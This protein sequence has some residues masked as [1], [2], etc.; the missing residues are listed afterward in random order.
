MPGLRVGRGFSP[1][2]NY[3]VLAATTVLPTVLETVGRDLRF[4]VR[5]LRR[6][7]GFTATAVLTLALGICA[8]V[9]IFAFVE[10]ALLKPLPYP[11]ATRLSGVFER[12]E[13]FPRSNLSYLDYLDWKRLNTVFTSLSAYQG[14]GMT[15]ATPAGA[16]RVPAARVSDDFFR[17]LRITPILGR[18]F[19]TGEDLAGAPRV[20]ML[21]YSA[22]QR[23]FGGRPDAVGAS[24]TLNGDPHVIIGV[25][26]REFHFAPVEPADF[27]TTLHPSPQSCDARR[28]CHNMFG[29]ARLRDGVSIAAAAA[30]IAA[31]ARQLE[32]QYPDT[33]RGQGSAIV[34]LTEVIVGDIRPTL[35]VLLSGAGLLLL[36]AVVNVAGLLI[37]R[38]EA[39][40]KELEIRAALG[41]SSAR[42]IGQFVSENVLIVSASTAL[43]IAAAWWST[44]GLITLIP[45][46]MIARMPYLTNLGTNVRVLAF[47]LG[48][49]AIAIAV[50]TLTPIL[51]L[52]LARRRPVLADRGSAG[53]A[54]RRA[55]AR[56]VVIEIVMAMILLVGGGLLG[57]S[58]YRL[59]H[60]DIGLQADHL[61]SI[62][63]SL[64][65]S[66]YATD[67]Q[68][69]SVA[70]EILRRVTALPGVESAGVTSRPPLQ[71]G[72]TVWIRIGGR[73]FNGEHNDVHFRE[74]SSGYL[75]T[76]KARLAR[77]RYF[78][79][80]DDASKPR[81]VVINQTLARQYF[82][83]EDPIG[84]Q[85]F[86][87]AA[88]SPAM[89]VVGV[90]EDVKEGLLDA[91]AP[92]TMYVPFAQEPTTGFSVV[93]RAAQA[94]QTLLPALAATVH[95]IDGGI[96]TF[97]PRTMND[98][99]MQSQPAYLRRSSA[100]LV[101]AFAAIAWLLGVVGLYGTV[102]Y[103]VSQRT[104]EIG[105]RMALGAER[106]AVR[107]LIVSEAAVLTAAGLAI[108][109]ICAIGA[110]VSMRGLLFGVSSWDAP[111]VAAA[112]AVLG[113]SA[114]A[115]SL[116]PARRASRVDPN[117]A[118]RAE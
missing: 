65:T 89:E 91:P 111:T 113:T 63:V 107:R 106:S 73:P 115:A 55:G 53:A 14:G 34:P 7:P 95:E 27:W 4:Q 105:I 12:V 16:Q 82:G 78:S 29:V 2:T 39:R 8:A 59:L 51:H 76:L 1:G 42:L 112:A 31:L 93:V 41:A 10:A 17:T 9:T 85:I 5:Q 94:E 33:N 61:A 114:I 69:A 19:R 32:Q 96:S 57:K 101:G 99:V 40:R 92:P 3:N 77:G 13:A 26:P 6:T 11:D 103:S 117:I 60:V 118:L 56:L 87:I 25:L 47:L 75:T 18:D 54:W 97:A 38:S 28:G 48:V 70:D 104:R 84:K 37:V 71:P 15:M 67:Q 36:I 79:A 52:S 90:I 102:A 45:A 83:G 20:A 109:S 23:R 35:L 30:N 116:L 66:T 88:T 62:I 24:V 49:A 72:N 21:S 80:R 81:V 108:G 43:G 44:R 98:I 68:E 86:Y 74:I 50:L 110:A 64:P 58:L 100:A 22:W 46:N